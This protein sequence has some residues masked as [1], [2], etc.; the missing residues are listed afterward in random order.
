MISKNCVLKQ[1]LV[2]DWHNLIYFAVLLVHDVFSIIWALI[3]LLVLVFLYILCARVL[4]QGLLSVH[5][6]MLSKRKSCYLWLRFY[7]PYPHFSS[8]FIR[9]PKG[10]LFVSSCLTWAATTLACALCVF[11]VLS[12]LSGGDLSASSLALPLRSFFAVT[13]DLHTKGCVSGVLYW[14][15]L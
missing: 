7:K 15:L 4:G 14:L 11:M 6:V 5:E 8:F 1:L 13:P 3:R 12:A 2:V 10:G 9:W